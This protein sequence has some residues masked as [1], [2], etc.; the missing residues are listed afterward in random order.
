MTYSI[1]PARPRIVGVSRFLTA[2]AR[3]GWPRISRELALGRKETH[4]MWFVFPQL[5]GLAKSETAHYYGIADKAEALAYLDDTTLRVRLAT[6]ATA[7]LQ[8][9]RLFFS[10]V[11]TRKLQAS[12]TLFS[13]VVKDPTIPY[14][15]LEK[16]YGG[17]PDQRTLDILDGTYVAPPATAMGRVEVGRHWE[18]NIASAR[19]AVREV[20]QQMTIDDYA[21]PWTRQ[22]IESFLAGF[23]LSSAARRQ[24]VDAWLADGERSRDA[25]WE[26]HADSVMYDDSDPR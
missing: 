22:R 6:A 2:Q 13:Q 1:T 18:K 4:W 9:R 17:D 14:D 8:H 7:V 15:I 16:F 5:R 19:A 25:G 21:T 12:M 20:G 11:D 3:A 10:D 24:I 26:S 23:Q